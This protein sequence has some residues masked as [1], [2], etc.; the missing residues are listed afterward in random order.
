[1]CREEEY[2]ELNKN[3]SQ[4]GDYRVDS[5]GC[6]RMLADRGRKESGA[7]MDASFG[8]YD[9]PAVRSEDGGRARSGS[10]CTWYNKCAGPRRQTTCPS[11]PDSAHHSVCTV[12]RATVAPAFYRENG[13]ALP[14][15][16]VNTGGNALCEAFPPVFDA[17]ISPRSREKS[18]T[19]R[20]QVLRILALGAPRAQ[21]TR[22][23][24]LC[25]ATPVLRSIDD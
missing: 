10:G 15:V 17:V 22:R 4:P 18:L 24:F 9:P 13:G 11:R 20:I 23:I 8:R 7:R 1:M 6:G 21:F 25:A 3:L 12:G 16:W 5:V 2:D 14:C 19:M